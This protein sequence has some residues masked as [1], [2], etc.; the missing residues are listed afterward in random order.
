MTEYDRIDKDITLMGG[1]THYG[2]VNDDCILIKGC[3]VVPKRVVTLRQTLHKQTSCAALEDI[4]LK[5]IDAL[6]TVASRL[7]TR[8]KQTFYSRVK[9]SRS[10]FQLMVI[11]LN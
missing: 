4:K 9:G 10:G 3:F 8:N 1:F 6:V 11:D 5:F 7:Q 2:V